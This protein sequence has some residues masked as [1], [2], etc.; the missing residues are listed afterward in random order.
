MYFDWQ[1]WAVLGM[2]ARI[3]RQKAHFSKY[4]SVK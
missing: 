4:F 2:N 1:K 3:T